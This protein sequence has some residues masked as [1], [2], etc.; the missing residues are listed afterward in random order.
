[1]SWTTRAQAGS[2]VVTGPIALATSSDSSN[3]LV[4]WERGGQIEYRRMQYMMWDMSVTT[5]S[6]GT[7]NHF[8]VL[9][10]VLETS[11]VPMVYTKGSSSNPYQLTAAPITFSGLPAASA[12]SCTVGGGGG[13]SSSS[14]SSSGSTGGTTY[15]AC[16]CQL[17]SM[18][19]P[20]CDN[21]LQTSSWQAMYCGGSSSSGSTGM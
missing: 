7:D 2:N 12:G 13:G 6:T 4:G 10:E 19:N 3:W 18:M 21:N 1:M 9:P 20:A 14:S 11:S 17:N 16:S 8:P 15:P 5:L